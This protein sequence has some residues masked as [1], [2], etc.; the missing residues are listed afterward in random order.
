MFKKRKVAVYHRSAKADKIS[1][2]HQCA[3]KRFV[4]SHSET[5]STWA[6]LL[7][8]TQNRPLLDFIKKVN[9]VYAFCHVCEPA[10]KL[11]HS[12]VNA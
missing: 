8:S 3:S 9:F 10:I 1:N 2:L 6:V 7:K 12:L 4:Q 11:K 5:K